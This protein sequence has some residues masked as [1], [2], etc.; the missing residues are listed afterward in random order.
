MYYQLKNLRPE[1]YKIAI[2]STQYN[3]N[4]DRVKNVTILLPPLS[5]QTAIVQHIEQ[6]TAQ[7]NTIIQTIEKEIVLTQEYRVALIAE[8]VTGKIDVRDYEIPETPIVELYEELE[9]EMSLAA[10]EEVLYGV[11]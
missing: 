10:E 4:V 11:E 1:F 8:A 3:L 2:K 6:E 9:E 5:E 7:I